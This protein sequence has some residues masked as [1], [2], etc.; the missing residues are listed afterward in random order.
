MAEFFASGRVADVVLIVMVAELAVF[1]GYRRLTGRGFKV[2]TLL[3]NALAGASL[4]V[5]LRTALTGLSWTWTALA[6]I[7]ALFA[8]LWDLA[9]RR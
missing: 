2:L 8:H 3:P 9:S 1:A 6:L 5:A 7:A 4:V